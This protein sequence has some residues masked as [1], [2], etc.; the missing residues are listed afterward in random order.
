MGVR[1]TSGKVIEDL[2]PG[3]LRSIDTTTDSIKQIW[4]RCLAYY[5]WYTL[6]KEGGSEGC[7]GLCGCLHRTSSGVPVDKSFKVAMEEISLYLS[8]PFIVF[9]SLSFNNL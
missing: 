9:K 4:L 8:E 7:Q 1:S 5:G 3:S 6:A 2:R